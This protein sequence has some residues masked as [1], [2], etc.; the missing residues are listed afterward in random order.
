MPQRRLLSLLAAVWL[1]AVALGQDTSPLGRI[2]GRLVDATTGVPLSGVAVSLILHREGR[3]ELRG[4]VRSGSDGRFMLDSGVTSGLVI[5]RGVRRD[6]GVFFLPLETTPA[7][8]GLLLGDVPVPPAGVLDVQ[9]VLPDA[10]PFSAEVRAFPAYADGVLDP[11]KGIPLASAPVD[12]ESGAA[13]LFLAPGRYVLLLTDGFRTFQPLVIPWNMPPGTARLGTLLPRE[14]DPFAADLTWNGGTIGDFEVEVGSGAWPLEG[15]AEIL[16]RC[17]P[18]LKSS[19]DGGLTLRLDHLPAGR[20]RVAAHAQ[21]FGGTFVGATGTA[22][23]QWRMSKGAA[24][25]LRV[26]D[27]ASGHDLNKGRILLDGRPGTSAGLRHVFEGLSTGWHDLFVSVAGHESVEDRRLYLAQQ[28]VQRIGDVGLE[29]LARIEGQVKD[30]SGKP[31]R[32][33]LLL[34]ADR[35]FKQTAGVR[36]VGRTDEKGRFR[37]RVRSDRIGDLVVWHDR[38]FARAPDWLRASPGGVEHW[39]AR[40]FPWSTVKVACRDDSGEPA[41]GVSVWLMGGETLGSRR[42]RPPEFTQLLWPLARRVVTNGQGQAV[43]ERVP[44]GTFQLGVLHAHDAWELHGTVEVG[45]PGSVV[46]ERL[47]LAPETTTSQAIPWEGFWRVLWEDDVRPPMDLGRLDPADENASTVRLLPGQ[48]LRYRELAD[49]VDPPLPS[50]AAYGGVG[51]T[52]S[53]P[54]QLRKGKLPGHLA[55]TS[56]WGELRGTVLRGGDAL[57]G[58][59]VDLIAY[60]VRAA[61]GRTPRRIDHD[62]VT[63]RFQ[64]VLPRGVWMLQAQAPHWAPSWVGPFTLGV[65]AEDVYVE[66]NVYLI[67]GGSVEGRLRGAEA[68]TIMRSDEEVTWDRSLDDWLRPFQLRRD[69]VGVDSRGGFRWSDLPPGEIRFRGGSGLLAAAVVGSGAVTDLGPVA[70]PGAASDEENQV[71]LE[72]RILEAPFRAVPARSPALLAGR[73]FL[74]RAAPLGAGFWPRRLILAERGDDGRWRDG[75]EPSPPRSWKSVRLRLRRDGRPVQGARIRLRPVD[76]GAYAYHREA[77]EMISDDRGRSEA[78]IPQGQWV[79]ETRLRGRDGRLYRIDD[80]R[81]IAPPGREIWDLDVVTAPLRVRVRDAAGRRPLPGASVRVLKGPA[82]SGIIETVARRR[83]LEIVRGW[84]NEK[85]ELTFSDMPLGTYRIE[86]SHPGLGRSALDEVNLR[87]ARREVRANLD[88]GAS[89]SLVV[90]LTDA[91]GAAIQG[92]EVLLL[93]RE[94][95]R[96]AAERLFLTD[97]EGRVGIH[98]LSPADYQVIAQGSGRPAQWIGDVDLN[99]G[100]TAVLES[101]L[102]RG[103][104]IQV[105]CRTQGGRPLSGVVL[106]LVSEAG[107]WRAVPVGA[108]NIHELPRRTDEDGVLVR[109]TF[110]YGKCTIR[111]ERPGFRAQTVE[112]VIRPGERTVEILVMTPG[113]EKPSNR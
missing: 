56:A 96:V 41:P 47:S 71:L 58:Q 16:L 107:P 11:L 80:E 103:G 4:D 12:P 19:F 73:Y 105:I 106:T 62:P 93:D 5:L 29:P 45:S 66:R 111:A 26:L 108:L 92:A 85:G 25:A 1:V 69:T 49:L 20:V 13:Q 42:Q 17:R 84:T 7:G 81:L 10:D 94:G 2:Q 109:E 89:A 78:R 88:L 51:E 27:V 77:T 63:G 18:P 70:L 87:Q 72:D 60:P 40:L 95:H 61:S 3:D 91:D 44:T 68:S 35:S 74:E 75:E 104:S 59:G 23:H 90:A 38:G 110:P 22:L 53:E 30:S 86:V 79:V 67:P 33:A 32:G 39:T 50:L 28:G 98:G 100:G 36:V 82:P 113:V 43:F 6:G 97:E 46:G 8:E 34:L 55:P 101:G 31:A 15:G 83:S 112:T 57:G 99:P 21:D 54:E 48:N 65:D 52:R 76:D 37:L 9:A 64:A 14:G 24:L 102:D